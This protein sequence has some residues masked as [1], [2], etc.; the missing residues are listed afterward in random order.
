MYLEEKALTDT[1]AGP[2]PGPAAVE[3]GANHVVSLLI[4]QVGM[5][6]ITPA[7]PDISLHRRIIN[8]IFEKL[9]PQTNLE[10]FTVTL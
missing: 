1:E 4:P 5:M 8:N 9:R 7:M 3:E 10:D 6:S 2:T